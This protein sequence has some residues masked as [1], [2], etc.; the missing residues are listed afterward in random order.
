MKDPTHGCLTGWGFI[1]CECAIFVWIHIT[2]VF[3]VWMPKLWSAGAF[4]VL[5]VYHILFAGFVTAFFQCIVT[6]PGN[7]PPNWGFYMGDETQRRRYCKMCNVWKPDR[8]HHC[9]VCNRCVLNMDHHCPWLNNCIGFF[10]RKFFIQCLAYGWCTLVYVAF[11][12]LSSV[13]FGFLGLVAEPE[14]QKTAGEIASFICVFLCF[15]MTVFLACGLTNFFRFHIKLVLENYTTIE[16]LEREEGARSKFDIGK[17]RNWE[18]VL[19]NN[20]WMWFL[21]IHTGASKPVGDGVRW[22]VHYARVGDEDE[23]NPDAGGQQRPGNSK[24]SR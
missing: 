13:W 23:D 12:M 9:S 1:V 18:Q 21:P 10:N 15:A 11:F 20:P 7:V 4:L 3:L 16:N 5:V 19:G 22:R 8:T 6:D 2:F 24:G 17:M 14:E